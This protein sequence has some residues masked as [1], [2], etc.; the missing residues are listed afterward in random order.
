MH[1]RNRGGRDRRTEAREQAGKRFREGR[2]NGSLGLRHRKRRHPVLQAAEVLRQR[3][4]DHVRPGGEE[5]PELHIGGAE[6]AKRRREPLLRDR[7]RPAF[8]EPGKA[9]R[10]A[11]SCGGSGG[12][13]DEAEHALAR[14]HEADAAKTH[15]MGERRDHVP[16]TAASRNRASPRLR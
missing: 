9:Q 11:R 14:E 12:G 10:R 3:G 1:L 5:L 4:T 6:R 2:R 7:G 15:Q 8:D 16:L 13:I